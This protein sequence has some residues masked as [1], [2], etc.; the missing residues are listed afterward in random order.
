MVPCVVQSFRYIFDFVAISFPILYVIDS[1][2]FTRIFIV[3]GRWRCV[4][5]HERCKNYHPL[6]EQRR[7]EWLKQL[8]SHIPSKYCW[9]SFFCVLN[10]LQILADRVYPEAQCGFGDARSII[11][12]VLSVRQLQDKCRE[13]RQ[14]LYLAF[15]DL[16]K[17]FGFV[18]L[19][20]LFALL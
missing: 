11:D 19:D 8:Q 4:P 3:M 1:A 18:S 7:E 15:I 9:K 17:A 6:Q 13:Q 2:S 10:R 20:G 16:T 5:R 12:M 14:P